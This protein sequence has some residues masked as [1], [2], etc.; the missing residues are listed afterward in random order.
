MTKIFLIM[1]FIASN[2]DICK[3]NAKGGAGGGGRGISF[4]GVLT[5]GKGVCH[6]A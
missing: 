3:T 6:K 5:F 4:F 2:F 1:I